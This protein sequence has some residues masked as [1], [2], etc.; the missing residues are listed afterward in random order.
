MGIGLANK[1][2]YAAKHTGEHCASNGST[3]R[4]PCAIVKPIH[5]RKKAF[6]GQ[7]LRCAQV[8]VRVKLVDD[9]FMANNRVEPNAKR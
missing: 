9:G 5:E 6:A 1:F 2:V 7:Q 3:E 8:K 4:I